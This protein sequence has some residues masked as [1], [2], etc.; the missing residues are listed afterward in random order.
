MQP[1]H[2]KDLTKNFHVHIFANFDEA[3][4]AMLLII[5]EMVN[6]E[7]LLNE[8]VAVGA[9]SD[10]YNFTLRCSKILTTFT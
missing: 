1:F 2:S 3:A 4:H 8:R 9:A 7:D 5:I 6:L 10:P